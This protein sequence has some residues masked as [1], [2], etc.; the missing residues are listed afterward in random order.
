MLKVKALTPTLTD[1]QPE[2]IRSTIGYDRGFS[3]I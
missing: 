1:L 3:G 2:G